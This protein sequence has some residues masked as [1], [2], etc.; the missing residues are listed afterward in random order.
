MAGNSF[1][2]KGWVV[3]LFSALTIID[4][5]APR[6]AMQYSPTLTLV[7]LMAFWYLDSYYLQLERL[8]R[9]LYDYVRKHDVSDDPYSMNCSQFRKEEQ[10]VLRIMFSISEWPIYLFLFAFTCLVWT[11]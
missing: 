7:M 4:K 2:C 1:M 9:R 11:Q 3:T 5:G 6:Q 8:F 10:C